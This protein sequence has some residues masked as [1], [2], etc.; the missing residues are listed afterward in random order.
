MSCTSCIN[1]KELNVILEYRLL[2]NQHA[3]WTRMAINAIIFQLPN[4]QEEVNRLLRNPIDFEKALSFFYGKRKAQHFSSLLTEHLVLA[5][6]MIQAMMAG[7]TQKVQ[8]I[9]CKWYQNGNEIAEFLG[10]INPYWSY[11]EWREMFLIH[12]GYVTDLATTLLGNCYKENIKIYDKF[13]LEALEM[14]DVMARGII[15]QFP[16]KLCV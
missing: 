6:D 5:A 11:T 12:L 1:P 8:E 15:R 4:Q 2:W 10:C 3:E 14:A 16:R 9:T 13:E 7:D